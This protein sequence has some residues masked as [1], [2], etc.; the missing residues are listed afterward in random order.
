MRAVV[1]TNILVRA[2][3]MPQGSVGPVLT[4]L[5]YGDYITSRFVAILKT[6]NF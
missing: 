2:L 5:R 6:I 4:R 3:I 1:D